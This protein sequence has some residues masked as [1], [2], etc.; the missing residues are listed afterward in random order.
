MDDAGSTSE[1]T[2]EADHEV[3]RVV[4][5]KNAEVAHARP[6]R[7]QRCE[8]DALLEIIFVCHHTALRAPA[9]PRGVDD[10]GEIF[11]LAGN[12]YRR[13]I[14]VSEGFPTLRSRKIGVW[15]S[16]GD[17][18]G[19]HTAGARARRRSRQLAPDGVFG[20]QNLRARVLEKLPV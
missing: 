2:E 16:L 4:G 13:G 17:K 14:L 11:A 19:L 18:N 6:K 7:V 20:D 8:G 9:G 5:G 10:A 3:D 12:Q 1:R 15:R